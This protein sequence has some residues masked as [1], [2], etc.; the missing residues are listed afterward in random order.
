FGSGAFAGQATVLGSRSPGA[1]NL[2][3]AAVGIGRPGCFNANRRTMLAEVLDPPR[4]RLAD[5]SVL[6]DDLQSED[7][8]LGAGAGLGPR[9]HALHRAVNRLQAEATRTLEAFDRFEAYGIDGALTAASWLRH[10]CNVSYSSA[11]HQVQ[12][13]RRLPELPHARA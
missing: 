3:A 6:I 11:S 9:L 12:L 8:R 13:A 1:E 2:H 5:L 7:L 4:D 10:R